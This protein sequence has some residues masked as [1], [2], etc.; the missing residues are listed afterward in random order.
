MTST[1]DSLL[2][3]HYEAI[4]AA[5][6]MGGSDDGPSGRDE[7]RELVCTYVEAL[8]L[9]RDITFANP[10]KARV[11]AALLDRRYQGAILKWWWIDRARGAKPPFGLGTSEPML[12]AK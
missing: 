1:E 6:G 7:A 4:G 11:I 2:V 5:C 9:S 10:A 8:G 12:E 3:R